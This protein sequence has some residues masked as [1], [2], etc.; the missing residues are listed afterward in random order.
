MPDLRAARVLS[1]D[2]F[3]TLLLRAV[4]RPVDTFPLVATRAHE[5]CV[6]QAR[7][8]PE[9]FAVVR[10]SAEA[11]ARR[12]AYQRRGSHEVSLDEIYQAMPAA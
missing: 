8:T 4:P 6:L 2:V 12:Q 1:V 9:Q 11:E 5:R 7:V 3:D 10:E